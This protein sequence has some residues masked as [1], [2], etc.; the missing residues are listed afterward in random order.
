MMQYKSY[1]ELAEILGCHPRTVS[2]IVN[3]MI[4]SKL[5]PAKTFL[6]RLKRVELSAVLDYCGREKE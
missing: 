6:L 5:Y 4:D 2:R 1:T 3:E